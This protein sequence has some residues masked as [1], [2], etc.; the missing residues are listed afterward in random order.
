MTNIQAAVGC[1]QLE[2]VEEFVNKKRHIRDSYKRLLNGIDGIEFF[3]E[4]ENIRSSCWFSG[5]A[6]KDG[7]L[8]KLR[9][10]CKYLKEKGIEARTF[11]KPVHLQKPYKHAVCADTLEITEGVWDKILTLPCSTGITDDEI[12]TV[13]D[14]LRELL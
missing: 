8:E 7:S 9:A 5:I 6:I 4:P 1:A 3:P 14:T 2:R 13:A 11:W 10:I 12:K